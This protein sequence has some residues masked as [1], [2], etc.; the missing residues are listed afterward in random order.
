MASPDLSIIIPAYNEADALPAAIDRIRETFAAGE[1]AG[2]SIEVIVLSDGSTDSTF[3]VAS[4]ALE[5][6][7]G[8]RVIEFV[9]NVGSHA[10]IRC[11]LELASGDAIAIISADGQDPPEVLPELVSQLGPTVDIAWGR[12]ANRDG[13]SWLTRTMASAYYRS[14]RALTRLDYP[15]GGLD[16]LIMTR[17]VRDAVV[18]FPERNLPLFLTIF[19]LG[20]GQTYVDYNRAPRTAGES[21]WTTRKKFRAAGDMLIAV[22]AAPLRL[23]SIVGAV[24]G[25]AGIVF[26]LIT[27]LRALFGQ[28]PDSGWASLMTAI[29]VMGGLILV[30]ISV[31]G[32][33]VWRT[34][35]ESR[36]RPIYIISRDS[37]PL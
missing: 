25:L 26:G 6:G 32:E 20:F 17:R 36:G 35:D 37:G 31:L 33:Y 9:S 30:G 24:V 21:G 15:E 27:V 14:F 8:G 18:A 2:I 19:N 11:G 29:S 10:V 28:T 3:D 23:L 12:R 34:L 5:E 16:F 22:S 13:D 7:L 1:D 4:A